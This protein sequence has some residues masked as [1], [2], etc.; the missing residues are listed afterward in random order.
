M[1]SVFEAVIVIVDVDV[2]VVVVVEGSCMRCCSCV[3]PC[4]GPAA[5][6][7]GN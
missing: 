1:Q 4:R 6:S 2:D 3:R 7:G 5:P